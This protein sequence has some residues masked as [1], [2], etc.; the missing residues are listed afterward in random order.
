MFR[1]RK[2]VT[3]L[4]FVAAMGLLSWVVFSNRGK[5]RAYYFLTTEFQELEKNEQ[6]F[7]EFKHLKSSIIF[8]RLPG[9][10]FTMGSPD[11]EQGRQEHENPR[12]DVFLSPFL[13]SKFEVSQAEWRRIMK[14]NPARYKG[15]DRP[16][17]QVSWDNCMEFCRRANLNLPSEAQWEYACR[18]GTGGPFAGNI[19]ELGWHKG[20]TVDRRRCHP[21]GTKQPNQFGLYDLHGNLWEWCQDEYDA[22]YYH[23]SSKRD[24]VCEF[25]SGQRIARG[26]CVYDPPA[27]S[28]SAYRGRFDKTSRRDLIGFRAAFPL[29]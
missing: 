9:G 19:D 5:I 21:C 2:I 28:R 8:V 27:I 4:V 14:N 10:K 1:R 16:V 11:E 6:G 7:P 23:R 13:I 15:D 26:G 17:E 22:H 20:N 24:P 25:G 12:H 29:N 3:L 18:A